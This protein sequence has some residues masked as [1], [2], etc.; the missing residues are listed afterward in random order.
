[1]ANIIERPDGS[2]CTDPWPNYPFPPRPGTFIPVVFVNAEPAN[3]F[4]IDSDLAI[5]LAGM[6]EQQR[7]SLLEALMEAAMQ[8]RSVAAPSETIAEMAAKVTRQLD[9]DRLTE[10]A[11]GIWP[12][13]SLT[14]KLKY[15][16]KGWGAEAG[17]TFKF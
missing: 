17:L 4:T 6:K 8:R 2:S 11:R 9:A 13:D 12:P 10:V 14:V 15:D 5:A 1:M 7:Q 16:N 3:E